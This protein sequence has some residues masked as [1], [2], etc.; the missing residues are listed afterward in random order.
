[1]TI[2]RMTKEDREEMKYEGVMRLVS[3]II[4]HVLDMVSISGKWTNKDIRITTTTH[5]HP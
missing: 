1:M 4:L 2:K 3:G 5:Y